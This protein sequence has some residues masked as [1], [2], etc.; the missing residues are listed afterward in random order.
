MGCGM[1]DDTIP[2]IV[3]LKGAFYPHPRS[4]IIS[5]KML[6][7]LP[8]RLLRKPSS[9]PVHA[10]ENTITTL[11]EI[12]SGRVGVIDFWHTKCTRCPAAIEKLNALA[13]KFGNTED[14]LWL[15]CALSLGDGNGELVSEVIQE[16]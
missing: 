13:E 10:H 7:S 11:T 4:R 9:S 6:P 12:C 14:V 5:P 1:W 8:V 3:R 2:Y 15:T 16:E